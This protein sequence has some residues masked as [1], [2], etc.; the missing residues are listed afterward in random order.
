MVRDTTRSSD[1]MA[2]LISVRYIVGA[3]GEAESP[4]WWRSE[5]TTQGGGRLLQ[6]LFPRT[7]PFA[8]LEMACRAA[9][10]RHDE[11]IGRAGVYHLFRLTQDLESAILSHAHRQPPSLQLDEVALG[12][13]DIPNLLRFLRSLSVLDVPL[14]AQGP[15]SSGNVSG[16]VQPE[17]LGRLC[18]LYL[19]AF[20]GGWQVY[21]YFEA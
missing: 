20:Q 4:P 17:T 21:P 5:A 13:G 6:R 3:L 10:R 7:L 12:N 19:A 16:L 18:A 11:R 9:A 1:W 8:R 2:R 14:G 15:I